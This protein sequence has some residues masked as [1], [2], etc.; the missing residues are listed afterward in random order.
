MLALLLVV[1]MV[2]RLLFMTLQ[3]FELIQDENEQLA[4]VM[5]NGEW[6]ANR[7]EGN[8][9]IELYQVCSFYV[10][11]MDASNT[12]KEVLKFKAFSGTKQLKP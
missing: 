12:E 3:Q 6:I 1:E 9:E 4:A 2:E 8:R 10:E 7:M 5:L 11:I